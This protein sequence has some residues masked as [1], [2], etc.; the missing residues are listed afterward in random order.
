MSD[1]DRWEEREGSLGDVWPVRHIN[2]KMIMM[3]LTDYRRR[4]NIGDKERKAER[5]ID[6]NNLAD[7]SAQGRT[8]KTS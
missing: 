4:H 7:R 5:Y 2:D 3:T 1:R 6:G 8:C